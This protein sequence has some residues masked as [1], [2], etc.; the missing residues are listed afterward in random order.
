GA[1]APRE[2]QGILVGRGGVAWTVPSLKSESVVMGGLPWLRSR[3]DGD[4]WCRWLNTNHDV[5]CHGQFVRQQND[6]RYRFRKQIASLQQYLINNAM[7]K[8]F[9]YL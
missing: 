4:R 7:Y 6:P 8:R 3:Q 1:R 2:V 5:S 9:K